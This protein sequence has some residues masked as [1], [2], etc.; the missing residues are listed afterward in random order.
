MMKRTTMLSCVVV[1]SAALAGCGG[2]DASDEG[3]GSSSPETTEASPPSSTTAEASQNVEVRAVDYAFEGLAKTLPVGSRLTLVNK[4]SKELHEM[5]AIKLP[6]TETRPAADLV[7]LPPEEQSALSQGPPAMVLIAPPGGSPQI[8]AVGDGTLAQK[9]RYLMICSIPTG[10]D[11]EEYLAAA[12][13]SQGGPPDVK[14][15]PPHL[16][17]G[18]FAEVSVE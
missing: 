5:V 1:L 3:G 12:A 18:M 7:K 17:Q 16:V 2:D 14:G 13:K 9:G 15:G 10:A 6:P 4:S 8:S 11:P